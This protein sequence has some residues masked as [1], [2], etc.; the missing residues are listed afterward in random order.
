MQLICKH[1]SDQLHGKERLETEGRRGGPGFV[2]LGDAGVLEATERLGFL[3]EP[4]SPE[5]NALSVGYLTADEARAALAKEAGRR[6][7]DA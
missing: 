4:D 7:P 5:A 1:T 2:D 3:L 6:V